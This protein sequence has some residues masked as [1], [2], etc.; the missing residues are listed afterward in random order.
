MLVRSALVVTAISMIVTTFSPAPVAA[1]ATFTCDATHPN[2]EFR[3]PIKSLSDPDNRAVDFHP[4]RTRVARLRSYHRPSVQV[5]DGT[6]RLPKEQH[7]YTVRARVVRAK[8]ENDGDV[9][10]VVAVPRHVRRTIVLEFGNPR[11]VADPFKRRRIGL[12]RRAMLRNCGRLG[13]DFI[14]LRGQTHIR[15][16]GYWDRAAS[17]PYAAP[18]AFQLWPVLGFRGTCTKA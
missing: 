9:I 8:L 4:I 5:R 2:N 11:C 16:V 10:L 6:A 14:A 17:E 12:A 15:G 7:A 13:T 18:N 1:R 3:W